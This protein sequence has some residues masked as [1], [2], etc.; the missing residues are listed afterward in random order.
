MT[1]RETTPIGAAHDVEEEDFQCSN[2]YLENRATLVKNTVF[3]IHL[4]YTKNTF[5][6]LCT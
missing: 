2:L 4:L 6:Y 1:L 5:S 3:E